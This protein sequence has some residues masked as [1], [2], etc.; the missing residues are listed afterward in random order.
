MPVDERTRR[1]IG[2][3][4]VRVHGEEVADGIMTLL[5]NSECATKKDL[6]LLEARLEARLAKVETKFERAL[7]RQT[8]IIFV[9]LLFS[10][11]VSRL[12]DHYYGL[13]S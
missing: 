1:L 10:P 2:A 12:V 5:P 7:R 3:S 4:L 11:A 8:L 6:Q 9:A 13:F